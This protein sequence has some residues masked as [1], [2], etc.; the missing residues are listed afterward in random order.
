MTQ[1]CLQHI[2]KD[3]LTHK[4]YDPSLGTQPKLGQLA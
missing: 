1:A 2:Y 4:A 3:T